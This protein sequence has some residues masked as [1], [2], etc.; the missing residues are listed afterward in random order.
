MTQCQQLMNWLQ[1][2]VFSL[3]LSSLLFSPLLSF[4]LSPSSLSP[5]FLPLSITLSL[6]FYPPLYL[7]LSPSFSP[8]LSLPLPFSILPLSYL[9]TLAI[10]SEPTAAVYVTNWNVEKWLGLIT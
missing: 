9:L 8:S 7:P 2:R 6:T 10:R 3:S 1:L 4:L 5:L